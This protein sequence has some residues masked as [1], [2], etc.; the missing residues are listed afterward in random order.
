M[1]VKNP[2]NGY[3]RSGLNKNQLKWASEWKGK[4]VVVVRTPEEAVNYVLAE[5]R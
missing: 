3:G 4:P 2:R 1:E 5:C